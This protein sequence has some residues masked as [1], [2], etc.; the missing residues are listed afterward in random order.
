MNG[1]RIVVLTDASEKQPQIL[2]FAAL[3]QDDGLVYGG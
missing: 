3:C 1:A 2:R